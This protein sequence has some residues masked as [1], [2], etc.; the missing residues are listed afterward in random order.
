[1]SHDFLYQR[2]L[3]PLSYYLMGLTGT[4]QII[5]QIM[6]VQTVD[7]VNCEGTVTFTWCKSNDRCGRPLYHQQVW[8]IQP[9]ADIMFP[10]NV[11][12]YSNHKLFP[13]SSGWCFTLGY[14]QQWRASRS[15]LDYWFSYSTTRTDSY[16]KCGGQLEYL[17]EKTD[18]C[19]RYIS[20]SQ[21][22]FVNP[23]PEA[24]WIDP[25][26]DE[27]LPCGQTVPA[28]YSPPLFYSNGA[29]TGSFCEISGSK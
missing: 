16:D 5:G 1:M 29:P 13:D 2:I 4:C 25:P 6:P 28:G 20:Y 12:R 10:Q 11:P 18:S 3:P 9:P 24:V 14:L 15:L 26:Q 7:T 27:T 17:W 22:L 23:A 21:V 19:G 8:T